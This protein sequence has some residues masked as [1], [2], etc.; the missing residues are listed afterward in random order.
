MKKISKKKGENNLLKK[1]SR[2]IGIFKKYN[3]FVEG[4]FVAYSSQ[5]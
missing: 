3:S 2:A 5:H 1:S 4:F